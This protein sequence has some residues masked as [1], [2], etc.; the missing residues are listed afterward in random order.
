[1]MAPKTV[2]ARAA[3]IRADRRAGTL[4]AGRVADL[5]GLT[6]R[7]LRDRPG[8]GLARVDGVIAQPVGPS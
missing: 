6:A 1:M 2:L 4:P 3:C 5:P 7:P 8:T